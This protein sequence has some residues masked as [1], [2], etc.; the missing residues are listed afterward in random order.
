MNRVGVGYT[1]VVIGVD[2]FD[3]IGV[4][5]VG[6]YKPGWEDASCVVVAGIDD[7]CVALCG[8]AAVGGAF[9]VVVVVEAGAG[10]E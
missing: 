10:D 5:M 3:D 2:F 8:T 7:V 9:V 1:T 4:S 6:W